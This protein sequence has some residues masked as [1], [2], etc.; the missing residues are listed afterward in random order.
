MIPG[1]DLL[2]DAFEAIDSVTIGYCRWLSRT[3]T[4][5][6]QWQNLFSTSVDIEASVQAVPRNLYQ[7]YGLD[8]QKD[9]VSIFTEH[10][11][12]DV[13]RDDSGDVFI[14]PNGKQYQAISNNDWYGIDGGWQGGIGWVGPVLCV[15]LSKPIS[16]GELTDA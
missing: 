12:T 11:I 10:N 16:Q 14:M 8:F 4:P 6:G 15:R 1:S 13:T 5:Q 3:K 7:Q 2:S 9:Y